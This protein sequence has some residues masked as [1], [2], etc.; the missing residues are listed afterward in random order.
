[1][2][3]TRG[4]GLLMLWTDVDPEHE[5]EFNRW[6]NEEHIQHLLKV[7]GF[8]SAGRYAA[9][10]G[11]PKYL[12]MYELEE[13]SVLRTSSFLDDVRF[14]P[15]P[16]RTKTSGGHVGRNYIVQAYRQ[17]HPARTNP[18]ELT[19]GPSPYLQMGRMDIPAQVEEEWNAWYNTVYIPDYLTVP[20]VI[21]V[22]RFMVVEGQPKYLTVY[23]FER[24]D[25]PK[26]EA[27]NAV[28]DRNPWTHRIR[29][30]MKLDAGSPA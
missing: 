3:K 12:A 28:R 11:G 10:S 14:R 18:V 30:F 25:V 24:P 13:P 6:Y 22:R 2:S 9:L 5:V 17:I 16:W 4:T 27:W 7:P 20:G 21:R 15:S 29:P 23:E 1:M 26:S 19:M 8:L